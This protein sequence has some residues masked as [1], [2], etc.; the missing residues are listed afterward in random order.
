V[1]EGPVATVKM[2]DAK[3]V[4]GLIADLDNKDFAVRDQAMRLL[5]KFGEAAEPALRKTLAGNT[6]LEARQRLE[7]LLQK[8]AKNV[9]SQRGAIEALELIDTAEARQ[10]LESLARSATNPGVAQAASAACQRLSRKRK[11]G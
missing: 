7:R 4:V 3:Q 11:D 1:A 8:R 9:L 6:T 10:V 5:E 2:A